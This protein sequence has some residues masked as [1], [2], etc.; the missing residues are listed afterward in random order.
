MD[1]DLGQARSHSVRPPGR[2]I[3]IDA[4]FHVVTMDAY[5]RHVC[6]DFGQWRRRL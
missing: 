2:V 6:G 3:A 1:A 4:D 5:R